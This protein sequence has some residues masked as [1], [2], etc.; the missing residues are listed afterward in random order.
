[1]RTSIKPILQVGLTTLFL[2]CLL[3]MPF[4]Y[5]QLVHLMGTIGFIS[6]AYI[7]NKRNNNILMVLWVCSALLINPIYKLALGKL[8]WNIVDIIWIVI[9][10]FTIWIDIHL[11]EN[12]C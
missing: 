7:E 2:C 11:Q 4:W 9:L 12:G 5:F 1:M 6:L 8:T 10:N 3:D